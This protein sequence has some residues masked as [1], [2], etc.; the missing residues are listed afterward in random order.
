MCGDFNSQPSSY[1]YQYLTRG[2][3]NAKLVAP[4]YY[5]SSDKREGF[6]TKEISSTDGRQVTRLEDSGLSLCMESL[7]ISKEDNSEI[8]CV[9]Y[10]L[11]YTLNRFYR[12]LRILGI[13]AALETE[14]EER[15]RTKQGKL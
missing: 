7:S 15:L 4:W 10:M 5:T 2:W 3:V 1:V 11:D 8:P 9:K 6:S 14:E 13:D 12:W